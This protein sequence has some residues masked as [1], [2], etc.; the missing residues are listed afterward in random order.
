[1]SAQQTAA[2]SSRSAAREQ[3]LLDAGDCASVWTNDQ[4][5]PVLA[6]KPDGTQLFMGWYD[7][8]SDTNNLLMEVYARWG[9]INANGNVTFSNEFRISSVSFP[10]VF[11]GTLE[12]NARQ[13][14]YDPVY[15]PDYVDLYWWYPDWPEFDTT[16]PTYRAHVG[17]YNGA[18]PDD[19]SASITWTDYRLPSEGTL[20]PRRQADIRFL[21]LPWP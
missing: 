6:V 20:I 1:M 13:G 2:P 16:G 7:R 10:P 12:E 3:A 14:N 5:M 21:R 15:P 19:N 17:E 18:W 4:W 9:T 8:R 11:A